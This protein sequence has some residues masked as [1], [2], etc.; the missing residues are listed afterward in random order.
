MDVMHPPGYLSVRLSS[1][2]VEVMVRGPASPN[3]DPGFEITWFDSRPPLHESVCCKQT[4][5][6]LIL[7]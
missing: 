4:N 1:I 2:D 3:F 5:G 6:L 7:F